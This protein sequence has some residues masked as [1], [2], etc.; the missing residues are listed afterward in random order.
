MKECT[1][2][3]SFN[4]TKCFS[5][6][7]NRRSDSIIELIEYCVLRKSSVVSDSRKDIMDYKIGEKNIRKVH[8]PQWIAGGMLY[9]Y[10]YFIL[11]H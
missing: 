1:H 3:L 5:H 4:D 11:K 6:C 7:S 10:I 8:W 9:I 2:Y